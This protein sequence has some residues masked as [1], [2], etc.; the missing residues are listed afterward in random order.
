M[1][2]LS[3]LLR[4]NF[5]YANAVSLVVIV[6]ATSGTAYGAARLYTGKQIKDG[7]LTTVDFKNGG[8]EARDISKTSLAGM[9][10]RKGATGDTGAAGGRGPQGP[11]GDQGDM[12]KQAHSL[13]RYATYFSPYLNDSGD[14]TPNPGAKDWDASDYPTY[15]GANPSYPNFRTSM[16]SGSSPVSITNNEPVL[17]QLTG[18]NHFTT[19]TIKPTGNGLLT[20]TATLTLMHQ[21]HG[22]AGFGSTPGNPLHSRVR[23]KLRYANN[24]A[25]IT[26]GSSVLGA[27]EWL[28]SREGHRVFT[29]TITGSEPIMANALANYN[30]GVSC[31]DIDRTGTNQWMFVAGTVTAHAVWVGN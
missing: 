27:G 26:A 21:N 29:I 18:N 3:S 31:A 20:A 5:S 23:C 14:A 7:T 10:G 24:G 15:A 4:R 6:V 22:E 12:G 19:G 8:L 16:P 28:S 2:R 30:V 17:V 1:S 9:R 25:P 13:V 11:T